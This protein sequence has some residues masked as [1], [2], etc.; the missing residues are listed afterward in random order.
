MSSTL[1]P[2]TLDLAHLATLTSDDILD[3]VVRYKRSV[4]F[5]QHDRVLLSHATDLYV[6]KFDQEVSA[7]KI[8]VKEKYLGFVYVRY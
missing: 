2:I 5:S 8:K 3:E 1:T 7:G 4:P 6:L